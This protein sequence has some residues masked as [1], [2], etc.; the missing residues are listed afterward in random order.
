MNVL[1]IGCHPDDV[2]LGCG[3]TIVKHLDKG[4]EV[5]ILVMTNGDKGNH[6]PE[7]KEC[8]ESLEILGVKKSNII[9][10]NFPDAQ[11]TDGYDTVNFIDRCIET[12]KINRIY[13]H[14]FEDRHQDHRNCSRAVSSAARDIPE[15]FLFEGPST[16]VYFDPHVFIEIN[17]HHLRKK[18]EAL[19]CY[20][21]QI[22]KGV[23]D[24][25][26]VQSNA[27]VKSLGT[28]GKF[29]EAFAINHLHIGGNNV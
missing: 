17:D 21:S 20:K 7:F 5:Y 13:T 28:K 29:A 26:W 11:L 8:F 3:G 19:R 16:T 24:L 18:I 25:D 4:D 9:F 23:I 10:G 2:E 14:H 27:K 1:V 22:Q 12:Y 15:L 6:H